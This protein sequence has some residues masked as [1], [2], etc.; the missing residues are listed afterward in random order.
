M[1]YLKLKEKRIAQNKSIHEISKYLTVTEEEYIIL[2]NEE[3]NITLNQLIK[4]SEL[5]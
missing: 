2:E 5:Y 4:L 3:K 1:S